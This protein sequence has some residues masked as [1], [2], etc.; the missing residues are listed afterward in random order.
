MKK[1]F[2]AAPLIGLV[3]GSCGGNEIRQEKVTVKMKAYG[4][5]QV[6]IDKAL[7]SEQMIDSFSLTNEEQEFTF[8]G[9]IVDVCKEAGCWVKVKTK[10]EPMMVF[11]QDHFGIPTGT[12]P[13]TKAFFHGWAYMDTV[14]AEYLQHYAMDAGK[15]KEEIAKITEPSIEMNFEADGVLFREE[16]RTKRN[17]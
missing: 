5:E 15:S 8:E 6:D 16:K 17:R 4:P 12:K 3:L 10:G 11:F 9:E 2:F 7:S 14:P 13:G 1:L